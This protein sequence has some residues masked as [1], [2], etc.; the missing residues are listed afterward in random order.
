MKGDLYV[1]Y[2]SHG[3]VIG[4]ISAEEGTGGN[5]AAGALASAEDITVKLVR[6]K[7][8]RIDPLYVDTDSR[9]SIAV[10]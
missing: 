1:I 3:H 7:V 5:R 9:R 8:L 6:E 4:A 10:S 2:N